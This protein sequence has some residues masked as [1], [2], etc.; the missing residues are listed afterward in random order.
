MGPPPAQDADVE[1]A[2]SNRIQLMRLWRCTALFVCGVHGRAEV[3][4]RGPGAERAEGL[5]GA[6]VRE[7]RRSAQARGNHE[8]GDEKGANTHIEPP[9]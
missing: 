2:G 3:L 4:G 9:S 8:A 7:G 1:G 5:L 6:V